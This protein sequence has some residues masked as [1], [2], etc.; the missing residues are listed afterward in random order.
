[1]FKNVLSVRQK[2][3]EKK[4]KKKGRCH[5]SRRE[6]KNHLLVLFFFAFIYSVFLDE[7]VERKV[8][9]SIFKQ[10]HF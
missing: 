9:Q 7:R 4:K 2:E 5:K 10:K 8:E 1:M 3:E 6:K